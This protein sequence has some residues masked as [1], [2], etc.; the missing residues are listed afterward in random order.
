MAVFVGL[1]LTLT[2]CG[3]DKEPE[4]VPTIS[5]NGSASIEANGTVDGDITVTAENTD[6]SVDVTNGKEW[7]T[8]YKNGNKVTLSAKENQLLEDRT[9]VITVTAS[10]N[11]SLSQT[12]NVVQKG[13]SATITVNGT[14]KTDLTFTGVFDNKS[15]I[16]FK[17]TVKVVSNVTWSITG[18]PE[19]LSISPSNGNGNVEMVIYPTSENTTSSSRTATI[20]VNGGVKSATINITQNAGKPVCY[21]DIANQVLLH[22]RMCWEYT[23]TSNV[24]IFQWVL[25]SEP[26]YKRLTDKELEELIIQQEKLKFNDEYLSVVP[27]DTYDNLL[28]SNTTYYVITLASD[29]AGKY[30]EL[31]KTKLTTPVYK[32]ANDDAYVSFDN[33]YADMSAGFSFDIKKEGYC[34]TY[35]LIYGNMHPDYT[36]DS[37]A[38]AFE[39]NYYIKHKKKHWYAENWG[40]EIVTDYP[41][42]HTFTYYTSDLNSF[43]ICFAYAWGV[44]KDGTLSSDILGFQ[45]DTSKEEAMRKVSP[46]STP[47]RNILIR[48]SEEAKRAGKLR[49]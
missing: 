46:K 1:S 2:A 40:M 36:S 19:W 45:W 48:R 22:D 18:T 17:Q 16:D 28:R 12:V 43:P 21:V 37:A 49:R 9:G 27:V 38:Y 34:N 41:N 25:L 35:H 10:A 42:N 31:R 14:E 13:A 33:V 23:A 6:W 30:G 26:D 24:N 39:I 5:V 4:L 3:S 29:T 44:F 15:G 47:K 11:P 32:D 7:L 20:T 8:A